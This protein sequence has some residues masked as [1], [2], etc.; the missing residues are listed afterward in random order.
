MKRFGLAITAVLL[1]S[2][3]STETSVEEPQIDETITTESN[4]ENDEQETNTISLSQLTER[5]EAILFSVSS[6][7]MVFDFNIDD[8]YSSA[9]I[10]IVRY[11]FGE[12]DEYDIG[13]TSMDV[14]DHGYMTFIPTTYYNVEDEDRLFFTISISSGVNSSSHSTSEILEEQGTNSDEGT[15]WE[16]VGNESIDLTNGEVVLGSLVTSSMEEG[17]GSL[18]RDFYASPDENLEEIE[19]YEQ[20]YLIKAEFSEDDLN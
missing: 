7:S 14:S 15:I 5:E 12:R 11:T 10:W 8:T 1:L 6:N 9:T 17:L 18:S 3:C 4:D 13:Q 19:D 2:A 20:V 16:S